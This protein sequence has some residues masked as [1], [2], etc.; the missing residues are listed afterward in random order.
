MKM[1][2]YNYDI[3]NLKIKETQFPIFALVENVVT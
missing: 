2:Q 1:S 3:N